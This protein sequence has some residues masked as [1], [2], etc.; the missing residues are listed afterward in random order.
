MIFSSTIRKLKTYPNDFFMIHENVHNSQFW[1]FQD[2]IVIKQF[3]NAAPTS[4]NI[5]EM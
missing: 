3:C 1:T 5:N 4:T 2:F